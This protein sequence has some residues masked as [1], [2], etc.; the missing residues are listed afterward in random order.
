MHARPLA[1][2]SSTRSARLLTGLLLLLVLSLTL[3][4]CG[5]TATA[6]KAPDSQP[7]SGGTTLAALWPLTGR[8]VQGA[9]PDRPVLVTKIDNTSSSAPQLGLNRADLIAEELVEGGRTRLAVFF[10]QRVPQ[11]AGPVRS[12]RASD[13]GIVKPAHGVVVASGAAPPTLA[14]VRAAGIPFYEEDTGKG[15]FRDSTRRSP[16]NLMVRLPLT[17]R[18]ARSKAVVPASYLPWGSEADFTGS[19]SARTI[20]A[21]FSRDHTTSWRYQG[22]RYVNDNSFAAQGSRFVP[23]SILVIRVRQ[24]DAGYLDP[25]GNKV[26]ETLFSGTGPM[27]L[28]HGGKVVRGTWA[29]TSPATPVSLSTASGSLSVPAGHVWIELVPTDKAGGR[30]VVGK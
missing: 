8:P 19:T 17:A 3:A 26:P 15:Y 29:K 25:A 1:S 10:Y 11:V 9:T 22:G 27:M 13:I 21:V 20:D 24:G 14:R 30:V 18:A 23:D 6:K 28:F 16:Y 5:G 2:G 12:M 7:I 4:G